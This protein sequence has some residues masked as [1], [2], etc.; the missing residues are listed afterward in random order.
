MISSHPILMLTFPS[1]SCRFLS[2]DFTRS[3]LT[4]FVPV[5]KQ[6]LELTKVFVEAINP[7]K[8]FGSFSV[9]THRI[10]QFL[11]VINIIMVEYFANIYTINMDHIVHIDVED[12]CIVTN[13]T[14]MAQGYLL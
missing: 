12:I 4:F 8:L 2:V 6:S 11:S 14:A 5:G 13:L 1:G 9:A 10:D 7:I 3:E